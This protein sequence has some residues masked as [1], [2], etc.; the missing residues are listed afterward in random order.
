MSATQ[1]HPQRH[2][3]SVDEYLRMGEAGVFAPGVRLELMEGEIVE[4]APVASAHAAVVRTLAELL[5][6]AGEKIPLR[7][8]STDTG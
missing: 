5:H 2:A 7:A 4:L 8:G 1:E 3:I 6:P